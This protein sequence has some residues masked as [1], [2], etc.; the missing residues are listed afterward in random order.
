MTFGRAGTILFVDLTKKTFYFEKTEKY[1][2]LLGG[3]G[4]NQWLL[5][6]FSNPKTDPLDPESA[7]ILGSGPLVGTLVPSADR[8]AVDFKNVMNH[9][10]GSGNSGGFFATEMKLAGYDHI[11]ISG[12]AE[13]PIYL[14][15]QD[16]QIHFKDAKDIWG[17]D[18]WETENLIKKKENISSLKILSIGI[19]G[20][21]KVKFACLMSDRGRAIGY[22]GSGAIFG[23]KNLKAIAIKGTKSLKVYSQEKLIEKV[24]KYNSEII[25]KSSV[26]A[27][28]RKGGTLLA[29]LTPGEKRPHGV[30]N[31]SEGFWRNENI[32]KFS[33]DKVDKYL[34]RRHS[35]FN[36][37][38][39]CSSIF[40]L[41]G[42]RFETFE[43]NSF[44]SYASNLGIT[45]LEGALNC[46]RVANSYGL[47][48]DQLSAVIAWAVECYENG[49]L[50]K[51]ETD[52]M[53]L[54]WGNHQNILLL[55]DKIAKRIGFGDLLANG[56]FEA[57]K[58]I[59]RNSEKYS[60]LV[61]KISL[62]EAAMRSHKAWALGIG[63]SAKG[64]GHLRG[65]PAQEMQ[66][67]PS[68]ISKK[69]FDIDDIS[70]PTEYK[71]KAK[72]VVWQERYK[73][74]ID[75]MGICAIPTMWTDVNLFQPEDISDFYY[76]VAGESVSVEKL[77]EIGEKVHN[78]EKI[79]NILHASF[80]RKDDLPPKKLVEI[81]VKEGPY[82]GEKLGLEDWNKMLD[83]YYVLHKWDKKTGIP[84]RKGLYEL[85]LAELNDVL[86]KKMPD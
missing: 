63:T 61:K 51:E 24:L 21:N 85:G 26:I 1:L 46:H 45:S 14:F 53:E 56:V 73:T 60:V 31:M 82:K 41:D 5:F 43:A 29:Y 15:I 65:A 77:F 28:R 34:I 59:G 35:C 22:G 67:V 20:E 49:I 80:T 25:N 64:G 70:N 69:L 7:V 62:M 8:L 55:I 79:F 30:K 78:L 11:F 81:P 23:S 37:P 10:I 48:D 40:E 27:S 12:K 44:R 84:G 47:D 18:T 76:L 52:G 68:E 38:V 2:S 39:Y 66:Q 19:A 72:L 58:I 75:I 74:I 42:F 83:E 33:R 9:G 17:E 32:E 57:S 3:R 54:R 36:C 50:T 86:E 16:D 71:D 6:N 4:I 13:K